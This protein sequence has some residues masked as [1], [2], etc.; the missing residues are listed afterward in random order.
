[1]NGETPEASKMI[2]AVGLVIVLALVFFGYY[3][4]YRDKNKNK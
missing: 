4:D 2:A 1:M 3:L